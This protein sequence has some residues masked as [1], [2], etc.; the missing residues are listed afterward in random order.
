MDVQTV[1]RLA[2]VLGR[3]RTRRGAL[4][5]LAG[6][7]GLRLGVR[8]VSAAKPPD[9]R[10]AFQKRCGDQCYDINFQSCASCKGVKIL[11]PVGAPK[12]VICG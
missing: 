12:S 4:G 11:G 7:A 8:A 5:M 10:G 9:C 2:Q 6:V 3:G 1:D